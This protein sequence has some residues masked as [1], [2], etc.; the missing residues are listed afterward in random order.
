MVYIPFVLPLA[1]VM[2]LGVMEIETWRRFYNRKCHLGS[3]LGYRNSFPGAKDRD[4]G[5]FK[6]GESARSDVSAENRRYLWLRVEHV[7]LIHNSLTKMMGYMNNPQGRTYC[8]VSVA[9]LIP[10]M[11]PSDAHLAGTPVGSP[12]TPGESSGRVDPF[13]GAN[14]KNQPLWCNECNEYPLVI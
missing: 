6:S 3:H 8:Y 12:H 11:V 14:G 10:A 1:Y 7:C 2:K 4:F 5:W 13:F 9:I